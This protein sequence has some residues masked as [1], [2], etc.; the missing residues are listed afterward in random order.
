M[1]RILNIKHKLVLSMAIGDGYI[2]KNGKLIIVHCEKQKEY[3]EFK[4]SLLVRAG[5]KCYNITKINNNGFPA[6]K[7]ETSFCEEIQDIRKLLYNTKKVLTAEVLEHLTPEGIA[8]WY[9]DDGGL[10]KKYKNGV[11]SCNELM[12]NTG[13]QKE[14]N[15]VIIDWFKYKYNINFSQCK[16]HNCYRLRCG[17]KEARKLMDI[18]YPTCAKVQCLSYKIDV[19]DYQY[20]MQ[21]QV[22]RSAGGS[23]DINQNQDIV[24]TSMETQSSLN[25]AGIE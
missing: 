25:K 18:I 19:K 10:S 11:L 13:L 23:N 5:I 14:E 12:L 17:T 1:E 9:L 6:Y 22:I 24:S 8:L 15:Q 20:S 3:L 7:L 21:N 4:H 16:N 2:T